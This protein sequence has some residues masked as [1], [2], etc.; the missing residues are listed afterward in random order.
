ME[1]ISYNQGKLSEIESNFKVAS[2][3]SEDIKEEIISSISAIKQNWLG[4]DDVIAQRDSDFKSI[5]DNME[6]ICNNLNATTK[7]LHEKNEGFAAASISYRA[8]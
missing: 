7:Y 6:V 4:S 8:G 5:L 1:D 3:E 2:T